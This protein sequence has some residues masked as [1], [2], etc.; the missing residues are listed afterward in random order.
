MTLRIMT[1][2][3]TTLS[4]M[5]LIVTLKI[6]NFNIEGHYTVS[7]CLVLH[8]LIGM[9]CVIILVSL[10]W[11]PLSW[12]SCYL[13]WA[14]TIDIESL[15]NRLL[16]VCYVPATSPDLPRVSFCFSFLFLLLRPLTVLMKQTRQ[17]VCA[18]KQSIFLDAYG[19]HSSV[20]LGRCGKL[21]TIQGLF[22]F[23]K[24]QKMINFFYNLTN[25]YETYWK[26]EDNK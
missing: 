4:I 21:K 11:M 7:L 16:K 14:C 25:S 22:N 23:A 12:V 3:T 5:D 26:V 1:L 20:Y 17:A 19:M 24:P 15:Q 18:I 2:R 10:S 13:A 9:L 8:C 6:N